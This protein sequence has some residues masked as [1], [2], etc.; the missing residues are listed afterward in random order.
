MVTLRLKL[1][2]LSGT[3]ERTILNQATY[4]TKN[5]PQAVMTAAP[6]KY[7]QGYFKPKPCRNCTTVFTPMA[8]SHMFCSQECADIGLSERYLQ[9][10]Y[11]IGVDD[12]NRMHSEQNGKCKLCG[13]EGFVMAKHHKL[14]LVVDHCHTTGE[15]RGLLCHNC[16]RALG[17]FQD[18]ASVLMDA[19]RYVEGAT[20][21]PHGSTA[22]RLEAHSPSH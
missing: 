22:K 14:K 3:P 15:V 18:R 5:K 6:N 4:R 17:L 16:N 10:N 1:C 11:S 2:E 7:P 21:I 8:P 20:T 13:G 12:Y 9:R 19:A